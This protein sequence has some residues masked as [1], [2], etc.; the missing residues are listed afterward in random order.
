MPYADLKNDFIFRKVFGQHP[1]VLMGLLNDLLDRRDDHLIT[2]LEYLPPD[3]A[4][5]I[6]GFK[7][8]ILD[9]KC[10]EKGGETFVV[11]MQVVHLRGFL[12]RVVYNAAKAFIQPLQTGGRYADLTPVIGVSICDFALWPDDAQDALGR[13]RIPM[14]SRWRFTERASEAEGIPQVQFAFLELAKLGDQ[15]PRDTVERWASIFAHA[16]EVEPESL[17]GVPFTAAQRH[18]LD[19]ANKATFSQAELDAYQRVRDEI[20][21]ARQFADEA[22]E[23]GIAQGLAKGLTDGLRVTLTVL[24]EVLG[25]ALDDER[26]RWLETAPVAALE[27]RLAQIRSQREWIG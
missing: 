16:H 13:A 15:V 18:A 3:Q 5:E 26:R 9:V 20:D 1:D 24:C 10:R 8:S 2:S 17:V 21:Q 7:L 23:K 22:H 11:E 25:I 12:N 6:P 27:E 19:L 4:P 14:V